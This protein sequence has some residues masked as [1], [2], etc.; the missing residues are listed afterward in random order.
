M[1]FHSKSPVLIMPDGLEIHIEKTRKLSSVLSE[2]GADGWEM[3]A[4]GIFDTN[5]HLL[6]FK[7]E[8]PNITV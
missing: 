2:L 5:R 3:I 8:L 4:A 7:R 6:Y 1:D